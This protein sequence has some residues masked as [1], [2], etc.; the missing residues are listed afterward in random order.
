MRLV[1][2]GQQPSRVAEDVRAALASLGRGSTVIGGVALVGARPAGDRPVEAVVVLPAGVLVVIGVDLP[3]PALRL[4]APLGGPWK[5]DGWPLVHGDDVNPATEALDLSQECE[6][7]IAELG[8]GPVGTIVAVGPYVE[9]VDQPPGD[10]AGPVRVLHPTPTT[11]LAAT[12]SLATARHPR[13]VDQA[14]ALIAALAPDAPE[15][16]D[17][18]LRGEGFVRFADDVPVP[19]GPRS[20]G[21]SAGAASAGSAGAAGVASAG[22]ASNR[23]AAANSGSSTGPALAAPGSD[24]GPSTAAAAS[25][26]TA[27]VSAGAAAGPTAGVSAGTVG[28]AA[29]TAATSGPAGAAAEPG[30]AGSGSGSPGPGNS[31]PDSA[32]VDAAGS[33]ATGSNTFASGAAPSGAVGSGAAASGAAGSGSAKPDAAGSGPAGSASAGTDAAIAAGR[34]T[35][36]AVTGDTAGPQNPAG[37]EDARGLPV[38][39][40]NGTTASGAME[41]KAAASPSN[42]SAAPPVPRP[43]IIAVRPPRPEIPPIELGSLSEAPAESAAPPEA[44]TEKMPSPAKPRDA[45]RPRGAVPPV[46]PGNGPWPSSPPQPAPAAG[47]GAMPAADPGTSAGAGTG[48]GPAS[49][50][51]GAPAT[52]AGAETTA[53]AGPGTGAGATAAAGTGAGA[54]GAG[55]DAPAGPGKPASR[56]V[57]W[58][59]IAAIVLLV[60]LVVSAIVV[61]TNGGDDTAAA[62]PAGSAPPSSVPSPAPSSAKPSVPPAPALAFEPR[63]S[64]ADQ[65]CAS[66]AFGDV[67]A[68]LQQTSCSAVRRA[69]YTALVDGRTAAVTVAVVEFSDA[70]QA[71]HLKQVA[72]NPGGGGILDVATETGKWPS[73][74]PQFDGAAYASKIDGN[75]VRIVQAVWQPGPSTA[76]DPGLARAAKGALDLQLPS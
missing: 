42:P 14:R 58:V 56:T 40:G 68:S 36:D 73:G 72:D 61:A 2:L 71:N 6:R 12:V 3:D 55:P 18:V 19:P 24:A 49:P 66:H 21:G 25:P 46:V 9:T 35:A 45:G 22:P 20:P 37:A 70:G 1:R 76:D 60:A 57:K 74:P 65:K 15:L 59:P 43:K 10:L 54:A 48:S 5:A 63:A 69:S 33:G 27:A 26:G 32:R 4:E 13:S 41:P 23:T 47:E 39:P 67:Q 64:S 62:P 75:G 50:G 34:S 11:M 44:P 8:G 29:S 30:A 28:A 51:T 53:A 31:A 16:S 17:E 38:F 7:R 52:G